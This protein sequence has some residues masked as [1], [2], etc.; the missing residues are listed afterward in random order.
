[1][2][3]ARG[4]NSGDRMMNKWTKINCKKTNKTMMLS[5]QNRHRVFIQ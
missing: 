3:E 1:M 2:T 4:V 5:T